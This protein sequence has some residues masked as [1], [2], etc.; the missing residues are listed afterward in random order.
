MFQV[1]CS[2][3]S[4]RA[5]LQR[6]TAYGLSQAKVCIPKKPHEV[7]ALAL[8][9]CLI[10]SLSRLAH[11]KEAVMPPPFAQPPVLARA[12]S[13]LR[14]TQELLRQRRTLL[15]RRHLDAENRMLY[16]ERLSEIENRLRALMGR[17]E[18]SVT[19]RADSV[20]HTLWGRMGQRL[21]TCLIHPAASWLPPRRWALAQSR[22]CIAQG[23]KQGFMQRTTFWADDAGAALLDGLL[24]AKGP[25]T[26]AQAKPRIVVVVG[27]AMTYEAIVPQAKAFADDFDVVVVLHNSRGVGRSLGVQ[28]TI[29]EAV[30]DCKAVLRALRRAGHRNMAVYGISMGSATALRAI[31]EMADI[32]ELSPGDIALAASVR[33]LSSIARVVEAF[34]S[35]RLGRWVRAVLKRAN[36]PQM[37]V[38]HLLQRP[39]PA[40]HL[41]ITTAAH[42][43]LVMGTGQLAEALGLN[44]PGQ[45]R[46]PS[47]QAVTVVQG[48][49]HGHADPKVRTPEHDAAL[50]AW[51]ARARCAK[52]LEV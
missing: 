20:A 51:A 49:G 2:V 28:H 30:D 19:P 27:F 33:G 16:P 14:Q 6:L 46:L 29:D 7:L 9:W 22:A 43:G 47:G 50:A 41:L 36:L 12:S 52:E 44:T 35:P 18:N 5:S 31:C 45:A 3:L 26:A 17:S 4:C 21:L 42:D 13:P 24:I 38:V 34:F 11:L 23:I 48:H 10:S 32:G 40:P 15:A 8:A 25:I 39:L 37:D 1:T